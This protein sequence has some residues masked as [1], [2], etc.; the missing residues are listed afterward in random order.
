MSKTAKLYRF[1]TGKYLV[2]SCCDC[3]LRA[4]YKITHPEADLHVYEYPKD[5]VQ[6]AT[7]FWNKMG[8]TKSLLNGKQVIEFGEYCVRDEKR[9][10]I[11]RGRIKFN[12]PYIRAYVDKEAQRNGWTKIDKNFTLPMAWCT[13][14]YKDKIAVV[15]LTCGREGPGT[16]YFTTKYLTSA[17][18]EIA[19][20]MEQCGEAYAYYKIL[21]K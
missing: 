3:F 7:E 9:Q 21:N 12:W 20:T 6:C 18:S 11:S 10:Y 15:Y 19:Y 16:H 17:M 14:E 4:L 13:T 5:Y 2:S 1:L 8:H